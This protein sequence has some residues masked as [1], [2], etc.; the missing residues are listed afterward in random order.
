M[1]RVHLRPSPQRCSVSASKQDSQSSFSSS[2]D[3]AVLQ[4]GEHREHGAVMGLADGPGENIVL[5]DID[6]SVHGPGVGHVVLDKVSLLLKTKSTFRQRAIRALNRRHLHSLDSK[7][8]FQNALIRSLTPA[9]P[10]DNIVWALVSADA[11][12]T[13]LL[14]SSAEPHTLNI[15]HF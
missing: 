9:K 4:S 15:R 6:V 8:F 12:R 3:Q 13:P 1:P 2:H 7:V 5:P 10:M 14:P 11:P